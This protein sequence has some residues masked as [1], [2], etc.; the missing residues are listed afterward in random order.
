MVRGSCLAMAQTLR[1]GE[2]AKAAGVSIE[3]LRFYERRG[4][5]R[6]PVRGRSGYREYPMETVRIVRFIKRSQELGFTLEEIQELLALREDDSRTC[7]EVRHAATLK[8]GEI[9]EKVHKL[10]AMKHALS[11]LVKSCVDEASSRE[12]P[13]LDALDDKSGSQA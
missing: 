10:Q 13:I 1:T 2:V 6:E 12:C 4:I 11:L 9:E 8:I 3:T 7:G 5:L